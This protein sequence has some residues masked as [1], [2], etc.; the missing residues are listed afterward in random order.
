MRGD[1]ISQLLRELG[2]AQKNDNDSESDIGELMMDDDTKYK[3]FAE[4]LSLF[5][6]G[7]NGSL[8]GIVLYVFQPW[9]PHCQNFMPIWERETQSIKGKNG[10]SV[11]SEETL[12]ITAWMR[13]WRWGCG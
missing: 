4:E 2:Q 3:T 1:G 11:Q 7:N 12:S 8:R 10:N 13:S 6:N 5:K 9:C